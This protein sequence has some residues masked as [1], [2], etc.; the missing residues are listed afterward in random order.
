MT[1]YVIRN[2]RIA[3]HN[4]RNYVALFMYVVYAENVYR[5]SSSSRTS[6]S[7]SS[8]SSSSSSDGSSGGSG[9]VVLC[10]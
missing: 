2:K 9:R 8:T 10:T 6:N 4:M 1:H 3:T 7:S 5:T